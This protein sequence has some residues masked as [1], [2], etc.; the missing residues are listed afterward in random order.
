M[1]TEQVRYKQR[2]VEHSCRSGGRPCYLV[3]AH[4]ATCVFDF[5]GRIPDMWLLVFFGVFVHRRFT[6]RSLRF[7]SYTIHPAASVWRSK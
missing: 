5:L 6:F 4:C 3:A 2:Q 1:V 7:C